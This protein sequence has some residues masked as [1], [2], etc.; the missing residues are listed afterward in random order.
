MTD[1]LSRRINRIRQEL[2]HGDNNDFARRIG[3]SHQHASAL[4]SGKSRAGSQT[5]DLLVRTFPTVNR[6]WLYF[7]TGTMFDAQQPT[8][9]TKGDIL[10]DIADTLAHLSYLFNTLAT[11]DSKSE[12]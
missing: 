6:E 12:R 8:Q 11:C 9:R 10:A 2:C 7:G 4:C 3:K 5:L 1:Q